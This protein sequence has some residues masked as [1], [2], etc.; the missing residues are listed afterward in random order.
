MLLTKNLL[1]EPAVLLEIY[2]AVRQGKTTVPICLVGRGYDYKDAIDHL[3]DLKTGLGEPGLIELRQALE[4]RSSAPDDALDT[5]GD[6]GALFL[7][8]TTTPATPR[9]CAER[10]TAP[11]FCG[12]TISSNASH[13][14][15]AIVVVDRSSSSASEGRLSSARSRSVAHSAGNG[16]ESMGVGVNGEAS[17]TTPLCGRRPSPP[18]GAAAGR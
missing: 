9:K 3:S 8:H 14:G 16:N 10:S 7:A 18:S 2:E 6:S 11:R 1:H 17:A 5:T 15:G 13:T 12:S 4:A